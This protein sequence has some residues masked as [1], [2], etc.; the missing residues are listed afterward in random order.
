VASAAAAKPREELLN[1]H[2][3]VFVRISVLR[4]EVIDFCNSTVPK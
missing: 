3:Q 1:E 2:V 4:E